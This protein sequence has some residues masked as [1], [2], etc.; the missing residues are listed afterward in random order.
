MRELRTEIRIAADP[1]TVWDVLTDVESFPEWNP[2]MTQVDGIFALG[3]RVKVRLQLPGGR[4]MTF[5]PTVTV[6]KPGSELR[7]LGRLLLPGIADGEH[8]I[9]LTDTGDGGTALVH[10]EEFRGV[11]ARPFLAMIGDKTLDGFE[12]MNLA[13]KQRAEAIA[14][15]V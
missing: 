8:I 4:G 2:F 14:V 12:A 6:L 9:E 7:W 15:G 1:S 3:E 13:L 10:R 5:K 11:L